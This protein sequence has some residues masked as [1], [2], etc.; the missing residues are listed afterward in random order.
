MM[1]IGT[2][3][4]TGLP[5]KVK[6]SYATGAFSKNILAVATAAYLLYFYTDV[7]GISAG[8]ASTVILIAK[9]WDI[10]NDPMM[11]IVVDK[12]RSKDGKCRFWLKY[13]SVPAGVVLAMSFMMPEL[14]TTGKIVWV[15]VTYVLQGMFSTVLLIP[16]NTMLGR[17]TIDRE[18]RAQ[19]NQLCGFVG[20]A[21]TYFVTGFTMKMVGM[22]G[23]SDMRKGFFYVAIIFGVLYSLGHIIVF[24]GTKG[25]DRDIVE[26]AVPG[27]EDGVEGAE[28]NGKSNSVA[29]ELSALVKNWP[30]LCCIGIYLFSLLSQS[31]EQSS[32]PFYFMY[33][34]GNG[35]ELFVAYSNSST[36]A[37]LVALFSLK[38]FVKR[39]GNAGTAAIG[40]AVNAL[41]YVLRFALH[42][43]SMPVMYAGWALESF[44]AGLVATTIILNIFDAKVYGE[45][46]TGVDNEAVLMS[47]FSV[48]Y[49]IGMAIGGP[50]AGY[51]MLL[52][53]YHQGAQH[54]VK[55]VLDLWF[56]E[57][58]LLP[59]V[60]CALGL[61][62]A[63]LLMKNEK[64]V[65][66]MLRELAERTERKKK[67]D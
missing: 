13:F 3:R 23:G 21:G 30:W 4:R 26:D 18:E 67:N 7:C 59:G 34:H 33:S 65:P 16:M 60:G 41:G 63:L 6:L 24:L 50:I 27:I 12:T 22:F 56:A 43:T 5:W 47:G 44:G 9:I 37:I 54:Q 2:D 8:V 29:N 58:T 35:N 46:K 53:P 62:F 66:D 11:G 42:D 52:V 10:I 48:S 55:S 36:I 31:M 25:Y 17:L 38:T 49:K 51:L 28:V 40:S 64:N 20:L 19:I 39:F 57:N 1:S 61:I 45:W 15:S 32:M 14:S